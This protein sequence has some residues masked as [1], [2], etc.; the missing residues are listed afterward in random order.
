MAGAA[1]ALSLVGTVVNAV[2]TLASGQAAAR[3]ANYQAA[4]LELNAKNERAAGQRD[5]EEYQRQTKL[6]LSRLQ[7]NASSGGFSGTDTTALDLTGDIAK[8][9]TYQG[10]VAAY[11]G[12]NRAAG[13]NAQAAAARA[14]G[15]ADLTGSYFKA[16]GTL[17]S[18]FGGTL[19]DKYGF[20]FGGG[21]G[22]N[23]N[24]AWG[25]IFGQSRGNGYA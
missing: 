22:G 23:N 17:L 14:T 25:Q 10:Q 19:F 16:G 24:G 13:L 12:E 21:G 15:K 20:G 4:Q 1:L 7:N 8:Y 11:G 9:G 18:G 6:V 3:A 2:G 5:Q